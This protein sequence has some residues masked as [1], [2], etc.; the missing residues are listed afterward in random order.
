VIPTCRNS[1]F[2]QG[3][4][5]ETLCQN[6]SDSDRASA[7]E[8]TRAEKPCRTLKDSDRTSVPK[9]WGRLPTC[10]EALYPSEPHH[11]PNKAMPSYYTK[12]ESFASEIFKVWC[13]C[14]LSPWGGYLYEWMRPPPTWRGQFGARW[15]PAGQ[16]GGAASTNLGWTTLN[17]DR[18]SPV[19]VRP[20]V[21]PTRSTCQIHHCGDDDF[22]IWSTSLCHQLKCSNLVP[23]FLKFNKH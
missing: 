21:W 10:W 17:T 18:S 8:Q 13:V 14:R 12:N 7:L 22:D 3:T 19:P 6:L 20:E 9:L 1:Y 16:P 11:S 2:T 5:A 23:K 15:R 4:R